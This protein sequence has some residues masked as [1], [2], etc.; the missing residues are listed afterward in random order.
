MIGIKSS[1]LIR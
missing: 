1:T